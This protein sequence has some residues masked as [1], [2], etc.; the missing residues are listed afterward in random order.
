MG[1]WSLYPQ[2]YIQ[3]LGCKVPVYIPFKGE[4]IIGYVDP[5]GV[6]AFLTSVL[7]TGSRL[8][9]WALVRLYR[10]L[11]YATQ[12]P[13]W[14]IFVRVILTIYLNNK[15]MEMQFQVATQSPETQRKGNPGCVGRMVS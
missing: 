5:V 8:G 6:E 11:G 12:V 15:N 9:R 13:I 10:I 7:G 2:P 3:G 1:T 4:L 14:A